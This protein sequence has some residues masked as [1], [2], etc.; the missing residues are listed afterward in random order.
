M[1]RRA[2]HS[3][4]Q[5]GQQ[6]AR[7]A[8][9]GENYGKVYEAL[10]A[11]AESSQAEVVSEYPWPSWEQT[12]AKEFRRALPF[13]FLHHR[14]IKST[15][16]FHGAVYGRERLAR[17]F[18]AFGQDL[19]REVL[20]EDAAGAPALCDWHVKTS[21]NRLW[22]AFHLAE[23]EARMAKRFGNGPIQI[24]EWGGGYGDMARIL[25][26]V[27]A[28]A[29]VI[30]VDLP[31]IGALQWSYL[32]ATI[33]PDRVRVVASIHDPLLEGGVNVMTAVVAL[34]HPGIR[35]SAFLSTWALTES[36]HGLQEAVIANR[37]FGAGDVLL[38][39]SMDADNCVAA[40]FAELGGKLYAV[41]RLVDEGY[42]P[43]SYGFM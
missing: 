30:I 42:A 8:L 41:P 31:A 23:Y 17:V 36:P 5:E 15:M 13:T 38:A 34:R 25:L 29:T 21:A 20:A 27:H 10:V 33:D 11:G 7:F 12:I 4:P 32:S 35:A 39:F 1:S 43:S 24:V 3:E 37:F 40:R 26:R 6:A 14:L 18:N 22:H 28:A 2:W 19:A 16:V 9:C